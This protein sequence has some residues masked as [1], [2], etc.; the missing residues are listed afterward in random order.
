MT[1]PGRVTMPD[2]GPWL[3]ITDIAAIYHVHVSTCR[4]WAREDTWQRKGRAP[5]LY[6]LD[7][8]QRS[9]EKRHTRLVRT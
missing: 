8:A 7:G 3:S 2:R 6:S 9:Y 5:M 1:R 4:R